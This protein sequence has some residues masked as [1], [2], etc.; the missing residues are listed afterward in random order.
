M[1]LTEIQ[2]APELYPVPQMGKPMI[3][4]ELQERLERAGFG[5][6]LRESTGGCYQRAMILDT[7]GAH[8]ARVTV[9]RGAVLGIRWFTDHGSPFEDPSCALACIAVRYNKALTAAGYTDIMVEAKARQKQD[10]AEKVAWRAEN[11]PTP[12][13]DGSI[14][15]RPKLQG[16]RLSAFIGK[17]VIDKFGKIE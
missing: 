15:S 16:K 7:D 2:A 17:A 10:Y 14:R 1:H 6:M 9:N 11:P 12:R 5:V 3:F 13:A 8:I 4:K